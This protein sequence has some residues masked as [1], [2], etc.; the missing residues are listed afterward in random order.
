[1]GASP[2][3]MQGPFLHA[4]KGMHAKMAEHFLTDL[5]EHLFTQ[6]PARRSC[7]PAAGGERPDSGAARAASLLPGEAAGGREPGG[8]RS[9]AAHEFRLYVCEVLQ[10]L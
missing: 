5:P 8:E 1:M 3:T 9:E 7:T 2:L 6:C 10:Q 4:D